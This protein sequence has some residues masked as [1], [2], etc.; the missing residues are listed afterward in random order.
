MG[1]F[2][3]FRVE[4]K[5]NMLKPPPQFFTNALTAYLYY[6]RCWS[7]T[8]WPSP[9]GMPQNCKYILG[10]RRQVLQKLPVIFQINKLT[11]DPWKKKQKIK[12]PTGHTNVCIGNRFKQKLQ[13]CMICRCSSSFHY[14]QSF[15][16]NPFC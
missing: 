10:T 16:K 8:P 13:T 9:A 3:N 12:K 1:I 15:N 14:K 4:N 11:Q 2:P 6:F 5:T 7:N